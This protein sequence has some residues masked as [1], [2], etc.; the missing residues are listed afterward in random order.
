MLIHRY[1]FFIIA[2]V[3]LVSIG[4]STVAAREERSDHLVL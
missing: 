2:C 1:T 4:I 3:L